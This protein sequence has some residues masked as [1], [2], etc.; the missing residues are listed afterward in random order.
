M[1]G[2]LGLILEWLGAL[3]FVGFAIFGLLSLTVVIPRYQEIFN[4]VGQAGIFTRIQGMVGPLVVLFLVI[5]LA[6]WY[7][8][9]EL[10]EDKKPSVYDK[11]IALA[12]LAVLL[13]I[14]T[15]QLIEAISSL[16]PAIK[17]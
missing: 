6:A 4:Q 10:T 5:S 14:L 8:G 3:Y 2:K 12:I 9:K 16:I 17:S 11:I 13:L 7:R 15:P 1:W